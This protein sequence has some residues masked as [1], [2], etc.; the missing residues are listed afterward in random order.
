VA[1]L[2]ANACALAQD[3]ANEGQ[4]KATVAEAVSRFGGLNIL[5]NNAGIA[6]AMRV[7]KV[8]LEDWRLQ[9][10]VNVEG[11]FLGTKH[12]IPAMVA[13]GSGSIINISSIDGILGAPVRTPYCATKGAV[14][15]FTKAVAME[16]CEFGEPVRV[17]SVHP[18]PIATNIFANSMPHSD[19]A[20]VEAMGGAEGVAAYYLRNTPMTRFGLPEEIANGCVFLASDESAFMTGSQLV[21]DGGFASGKLI[22]QRLPE[23]M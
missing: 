21:I 12:A 18:G 9:F 1:K 17:N 13:S 4:W 5:V 6:R 19:P 20:M 10:A 15:A 23:G 22:N 16:C 14:A 2:G 3:V 8:T 11:V 7:T